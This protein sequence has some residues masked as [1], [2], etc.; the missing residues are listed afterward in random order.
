MKFGQTTNSP[1]VNQ[2]APIAV[3]ASEF[4]GGTERGR[5]SSFYDETQVDPDAPGVAL[6]ARVPP[7]TMVRVTNPATGQ[8]IVCPVRDLGPHNLN[9]PYWNHP[10]QVQPPKRSMLME[11]RRK[12]ITFPG[13][14]PVLILLPPR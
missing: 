4:A 5:T 9:D 10:G 6:P 13:T 11:F 14:P 3:T 7:G 12:T 1:G 8:S 2:T